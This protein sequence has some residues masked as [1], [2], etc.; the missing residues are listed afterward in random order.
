MSR[1]VQSKPKGRLVS[2]RAVGDDGAPVAAVRD[3][4]RVAEPLHQLRPRACDP[5]GGPSGL[6]GLLRE[7]EPGERRDHHV[8]RIGGVSSVRNRAATITSLLMLGVPEPRAIAL[9]GGQ[10]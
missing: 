3:P 2:M 10:P 5:P 9:A 1:V 8:E 7:P 6:G 4:A